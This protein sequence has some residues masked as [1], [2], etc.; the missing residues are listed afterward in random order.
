MFGEGPTEIHKLWWHW[1]REGLKAWCNFR[2]NSISLYNWTVLSLQLATVNS[3]ISPNHLPLLYLNW[4][5]L[6]KDYQL[7]NIKHVLLS[8]M[9]PDVLNNFTITF[10]FWFLAFAQFCISQ[11][12][13]CSIYNFIIESS[14]YTLPRMF[15][16]GSQGNGTLME[17]T[18]LAFRGCYCFYSTGHCF[19]GCRTSSKHVS[20]S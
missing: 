1:L 16:C 8:T 4:P 12:Q 5:V 15:S 19:I 11:F 7:L 2:Q 3:T 17:L 10:Y 18:A 9:L 13:H 14:F 20:K 6:I